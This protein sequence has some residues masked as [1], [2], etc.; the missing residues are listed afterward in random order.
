[1]CSYYCCR[2]RCSLIHF[3]PKPVSSDLLQDR[4]LFSTPSFFYS[5][6]I[7]L[8]LVALSTPVV[9]TQHYIFIALQRRTTKL[10]QILCY[11]T[12]PFKSLYYFQK[13]KENLV[14]PISLEL[15]IFTT[16]WTRCNPPDNY[17]SSLKTCLMA[18]WFSCLLFPTFQC[19]SYFLS[20]LFPSSSKQE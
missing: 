5:L 3:I 14:I 9:V 15:S 12:F 7:P 13:G 10:T 2:G 16:I 18:C 1:M 20:S 11:T 8:A 6:I 4:I 19:K 17:F